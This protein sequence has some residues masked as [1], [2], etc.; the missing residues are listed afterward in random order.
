MSKIAPPTRQTIFQMAARKLRQEFEELRAIPHAGA[1]GGE[2]ERLLRRFLNDHL[3]KRFA[4]GAGFIIDQRDQ[5]SRQSDVVV[6]DAMNC[7][8][9]RASE[10]AAIFPSDNVAAVVEVKSRL[11]KDRLEEAYDNVRAAKRLSKTKAPDVPFLVETQT[12]GCVFAFESALCLETIAAHYKDLLAS[13]TIGDHID[14]IA[15]LDRG[16]VMLNAQMPGV[17]T[18]HPCILD[19]LGGTM[20]EGWHLAIG[21][22]ALGD[23]TLDA[24]LR[25]LL[26]HLSFFRGIVDHP[27]FRWNAMASGGQVHLTY[28]TSITQEQDPERRKQKLKDY[29][30]QVIR[31]FSVTKKV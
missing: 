17:G 2:A 22:Q 8:V 12:L 7:P 5:V 25:L 30:D 19:G 1:K 4:A 31:E 14:L 13:K 28:L 3:P 20:G 15:V 21:A 11:D 18:W 10:D 6:Y 23:D 16:M 9:Y 24:F 29:A 26:A 27:G